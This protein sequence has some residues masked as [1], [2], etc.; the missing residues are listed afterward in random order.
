LPFIEDEIGRAAHQQ[1]TLSVRA[2]VVDPERGVVLLNLVGSDASVSAVAMELL[3]S[4]S[5]GIGFLPPLFGEL[6]NDLPTQPGG[7][8]T[9]FR[10]ARAIASGSLK[11]YAKQ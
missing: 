7:R 1:H 8:C 10:S 9:I 4:K 3:R 6:P 11:W 2:L 5:G